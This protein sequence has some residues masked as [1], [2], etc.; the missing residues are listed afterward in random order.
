MKQK[1]DG[2]AGMISDRNKM[3][4]LTV[5]LTTVILNTGTSCI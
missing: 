2:H 4:I 5:V 1:H 3:C